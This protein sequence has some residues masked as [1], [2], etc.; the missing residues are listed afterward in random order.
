M[1]T[2]KKNEQSVPFSI[3]TDADFYSDG[4]SD[5]SVDMTE[6]G[7]AMVVS[8]TKGD[9]TYL[10]RTVDDLLLV[11]PFLRTT[12][13]WVPMFA[14]LVNYL[15]EGYRFEII[16]QP[17]TFEAT[18]RATYEAEDPNEEVGPGVNRLHNYG[19]PRFSEIAPPRKEGDVLIFYAENMY[20]GYPYK[21]T[22]SGEGAPE[23]EPVTVVE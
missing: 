20:M 4:T 6:D 23:Y 10:A 12:T 18:Y 11:M 13:Q 19:L 21:V 2:F 3:A 15:S 16:M 8:V 5:I 14:R 1:F 7:D 17:E 9:Q 22:Y